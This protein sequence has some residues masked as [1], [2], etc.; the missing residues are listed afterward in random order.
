MN[1][2]KLVLFLELCNG[3]SISPA[4]CQ[5]G[6]GDRSMLEGINKMIREVHAQKELGLHECRE[7]PRLGAG[8]VAGCCLGQ[9]AR[10]WQ[11]WWLH[12]W[13]CAPIYGGWRRQRPGECDVMGKPQAQARV[14]LM[15]AEAQALAEAEQEL[16]HL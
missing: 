11:H 1:F 16:M 13:V 2:I 9:Q 12:H 4:C 15:A 6:Q 7:G 5:V 8:G 10:P 3:V 14:P